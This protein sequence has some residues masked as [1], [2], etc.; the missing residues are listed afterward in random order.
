[1]A[2]PEKIGGLAVLDSLQN[3]LTSFAALLCGFAVGGTWV[4]VVV[5]P[6]ESFDH[7]DHTRADRNVRGTL[8]AAS[9]PIAIMLLAASALAVLGGA[10]GAG[11]RWTLAPRKPRSAPPGARQRKKTQRVVAVALSLIFGVGSIAAGVMAA[12]QI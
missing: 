9:T 3:I 7:M 8:V 2:G 1:M 12:L 10:L 5:V 6:N 4:G 11:N